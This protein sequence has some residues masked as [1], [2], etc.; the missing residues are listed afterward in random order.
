MG[1]ILVADDDRTCRDSIQKTLEREGYIVESARDVDSAMK[2]AA[3]HSLDLIVCDYRM[4]GKT[5][6]DLLAELKEIG[7]KVPVLMISAFADE[8]TEAAAKRLGVR[9]LLKKPFRRQ[10]LLDQTFQALHGMV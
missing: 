1:L 7:S 3:E 9:A 4:P 6:L 8:N 5:G 10:E 2:V